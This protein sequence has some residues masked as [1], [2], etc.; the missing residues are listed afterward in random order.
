MTQLLLGYQHLLKIEFLCILGFSQV[1]V[2][3]LPLIQPPGH[4]TCYFH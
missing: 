4:Y 1:E 3:L 2:L